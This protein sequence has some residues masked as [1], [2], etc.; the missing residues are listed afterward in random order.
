M[1]VTFKALGKL[2][3]L[4]N[5]LFQIAAT[6]GAARRNG[7]EFVFPPWPYSVFFARPLPQSASLPA[8]G[9]FV[10]RSFTYQDI[11]I[12]G[13]TDL[14]GFF[15]SEKYFLDCAE[16]IRALLTPRPE[17]V[18]Q[19]R[20]AF[21]HLRDKETCSIHVRRTDYVGRWRGLFAELAA[22]DYYERAM[23]RFD[24]GTKFLVFSDDIPWCKERFRGER[25]LFIEGL[26]DIANL[27]LM[28]SC[29]GHIIANS[30]SRKM[31]AWRIGRPPRRMPSVVAWPPLRTAASH[32]SATCWKSSRRVSNRRFGAAKRS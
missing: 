11:A 16:E 7:A 6:V 3:R 31:G 1:F 10:E 19:L 32:S 24:K 26:R 29:R 30:C 23:A 28:A 18:G 8:A 21:G 13:P 9:K 5:Q 27:F 15:Q 2:G 12:A 20:A 25:F 4:G 22:G 14:V 17:F